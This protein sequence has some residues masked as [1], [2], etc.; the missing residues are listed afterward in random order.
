MKRSVLVTAIA[1][2]QSLLTLVLAGVT[3]YLVWLAHSPNILAEPD[4]A[5]ASHGLMIG[6]KVIA[7]PAIVSCI[8]SWG[9]W[10]NKRWGWWLALVMHVIIFA[11][12]AYGTLN[13]NSIDTEEIVVTLCFLVVPILLLLPR[14]RKAYWS[15]AASQ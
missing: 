9:L 14:V 1:V 10:K 3:I 12:L 5:D 2:L 7:G 13:E 11:T 4:A 6:A 15:S 8:S